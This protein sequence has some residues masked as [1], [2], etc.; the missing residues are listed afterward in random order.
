M[1]MN[2][3]KW[4]KNKFKNKCIRFMKCFIYVFILLLNLRITA[5]AQT[6]FWPQTY[7]HSLQTRQQLTNEKGDKFQSAFDHAVSALEKEPMRPE[8]HI[9]LGN[10]LEG[11]GS[12]D[13][14]ID[15]YGVAA[16]ISQDPQIQFISRF[17]QAQA[18]AKQKK[19][20]EALELY[21]SALEVNPESIE[22]KTN[23]ELLMASGGGK[24][25]DGK[26]SQD[27]SGEGDGQD[28]KGKEPQKFSE[29]PQQKKNQPKNLSESDVKKILQ[30]LK[31]QEQR[32]RGDYY[33]QGQ[34]ER[35]QAEGDGK[36]EKD[37]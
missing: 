32:I 31:Q 21:Q 20:D 35:K 1:S 22:T 5:I 34:R 7:W 6:T 26:E 18:R 4:I 36:R 13:R 37:W 16:K 19:V 27:Q 9:N 23:I 11:M 3:L 30:E 12:L 14:A 17:N 15:A 8:L 2:E 24:G 10:A 33:K 25:K 29:N 28:Q